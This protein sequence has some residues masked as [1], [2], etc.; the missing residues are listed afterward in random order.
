MRLAARAHGWL[1]VDEATGKARRV[2][3]IREL[4]SAMLARTRFVLL[5]PLFPT[6]SH[7]NWRP[8]PRKRAA[9]L[10]R[11]GGRRL[12]ALG[13]MDGMRFRRIERLGF[14]GW[15]GISAWLRT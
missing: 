13:G 12:I 1:I 9:A 15:A 10:A 4:R 5:S 7:P 2:H 8:L 6:H 11:L 14:I 3:D